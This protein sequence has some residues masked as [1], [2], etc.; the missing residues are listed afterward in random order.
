MSEFLLHNRSGTLT[1]AG[2]G[3]IVSLEKDGYEL[4]HPSLTA[5][6]I[7]LR[8]ENGDLLILDSRDFKVR[9]ENAPD[10][11][12]TVCFS[13]HQRFPELAVELNIR[14]DETFFYFNAAVDGVPENHLPEWIDPVQPLLPPGGK[15]F[16]PRTEGI[17]IDDLRFREKTHNKYH[18]AGFL[19]GSEGGYYPGVCQMQFMTWQ[20]DGFYLYF[21]AHDPLHGTKAVEFAPEGENLT[22]LSLQTFCGDQ[23]PYRSGFDYV[24]AAG[25]GDWMDGCAIYRQW[26]E[27]V[28]GLPPKGEF[29]EM[30]RHS[31][32]VLIYPVRGSGTDTGD[33]PDIECFFPYSNA[34]DTVDDYAE[35]TAGCQ[36]ALLMHWEGTAPWAPPYVWPP[37]GGEK[38]LH[39]Y[40]D[41]LHRH[42]HY[43]GVYCSGTAWTQKSSITDYNMEKYCA[44]NDLHREMIRGP[45]HEINAVICNGEDS[46]RI[47]YDMCISR[48]WVKETV[49]NEVKKLT[50]LP[51]D[52]AQFFDQNL[53][54]A[55]HP[56]YSREHGHPGCPGKWQTDEMKDLLRQCIHE[57]MIIGA[58]AAAAHPYI[59]YLKFNDLRASFAWN[60]GGVPV[61]GYE[62]VFHE[63]ICNFQ[64]NQCGISYHIDSDRSPE[65]LLYRLA[66]AFTGGNLLSV[67]LDKHGKIHWGWVAPWEMDRPDQDSAVT[68]IRNLNKVRRENPEVLLYGRM[69]KPDYSIECDKYTLHTF[70]G[71]REMDAVLNSCWETP[72]GCRKI[73]LTNFLPQSQQVTIISAKGKKRLETAPLSA[74]ILEC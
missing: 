10:G 6:T 19:D 15:L 39:D 2:N 46:Q 74:V 26:A 3:R 41:A 24:I 59:E 60:F 64:G 58:E 52:Y 36:L 33:M 29:P 28:P 72:D 5:F 17:L 40:A 71:D 56:C 4:L 34:L 57:N 61:P 32:L 16:W 44:E 23:R 49:V 21:A 65:S 62:F 53:G 47:G 22:R 18:I 27:S 37:Y 12:I 20:R 14:A 42:G 63:Y 48:Q 43:L 69:L 1:V 25:K 31:P 38:M 8:D 73:V 67:T 68:L 51:I 55:F 54:G 50:T 30:L 9:P 45:H 7:G 35:K 11:N 13:G 66:Y 70:Y